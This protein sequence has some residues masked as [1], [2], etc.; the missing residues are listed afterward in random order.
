MEGGETGGGGEIRVGGEGTNVKEITS[1]AEDL[2]CSGDK[3][4]TSLWG[5][6]Q[7]GLNRP[8]Q[9]VGEIKAVVALAR[10]I[11]C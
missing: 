8:E 11:A 4:K 1:K 5:I 9:V 6:R 7:R 3:N 10:A 2:R